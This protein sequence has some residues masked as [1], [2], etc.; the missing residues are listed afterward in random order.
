LGADHL[1]AS[2]AQRL[3]NRPHALASTLR[4][5]GTGRMPPLWEALPDL[6][7]PAL[8]LAGA[9]DLKFSK[10][11]EQ[12]A[13]RIPRAQL[14]IIPGAGHAL[15]LEAPEPLSRAIERFLGELDPQPG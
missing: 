3:R 11:A 13:E 14:R 10:L 1:T 15:H 12:M 2:R 5:L 7:M 6:P 9:L 4:Q 8:L